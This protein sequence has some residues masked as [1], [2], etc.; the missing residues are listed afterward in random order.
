MQ[1]EHG[2]TTETF[3]PL[4]RRD[5]DSDEAARTAP[6]AQPRDH[7]RESRPG[8]PA[9][10]AGIADHQHDLGTAGGPRRAHDARPPPSPSHNSSQFYL[11][12]LLAFALAAWGA[13]KRFC[14][15]VSLT[16]MS[17]MRRGT[18][19]NSERFACPLRQ[20]G[21]HGS[22]VRAPT[23]RRRHRGRAAEPSRGAG[24]A[25]RELAGARAARR[26]V[27][28]PNRAPL[29]PCRAHAQRVVGQ[30]RATLSL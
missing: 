2:P 3:L 19:F 10:C 18:H 1:S 12:Y 23:A 20:L 15:V 7:R 16:K 13:Q 22:G 8:G 9:A 14:V 26:P 24:Q 25:L 6:Q 29:G 27:Q 11:Q 30:P 4:R 28:A 5:R 21:H 17:V